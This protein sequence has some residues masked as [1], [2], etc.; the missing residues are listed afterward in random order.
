MTIDCGCALALCFGKKTLHDESGFTTEDCFN[1][2]NH[3]ATVLPG[4]NF[5]QTCTGWSLC[6]TILSENILAG[7]SC[8]KPGKGKSNKQVT[9]NFILSLIYVKVFCLDILPGFAHNTIPVL[10]NEMVL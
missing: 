10:A 4:I 7:R 5:P 2:P 6:S 9:S 3:T 8:D 1:L